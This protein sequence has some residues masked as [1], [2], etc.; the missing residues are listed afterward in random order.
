MTYERRQ[1]VGKVDK[2]LEGDHPGE[3]K[4]NGLLQP[5]ALQEKR[6]EA[7]GGVKILKTSPGYPVI[8]AA[9]S[10]PPLAQ[11]NEV[12]VRPPREGLRKTRT[13]IQGQT[14]LRPKLE[15]PRGPEECEERPR[16][17]DRNALIIPC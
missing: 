14:P 12:H 16:E 7:N 17:K 3:K 2:D 9:R 6:G 10:R 4:E 1:W 5:K 13:T 15:R 8:Y 11:K